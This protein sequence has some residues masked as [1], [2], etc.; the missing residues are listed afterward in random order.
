MAKKFVKTCALLCVPVLALCMAACKS[1]VGENSGYVLLDSAV[2]PTVSAPYEE[3]S[4]AVI[5][6]YLSVA[7]D[8]LDEDGDV[9][10]EDEDVQQAAIE[11]AAELYAYACYNEAYIDKYVYFSTQSGSTTYGSLGTS[12]ATSQNYRLIVNGDD[13][14]AGYKY[15]Y[16]IKKV[17][18]VSSQALELFK[19][20]FE[21][22]TL[23]FVVDTNIL[24]RLAGEDVHYDDEGYLTCTW[25]VESNESDWGVEDKPAI[26]KKS[27]DKLTLEGIKQDI[28]EVAS[29]DPGN[30]YIHG[31]IN[32]LKDGIVNYAKITPLDSELENTSYDSEDISAY[33]I[34]MQIDT[35]V[36]NSDEASQNMLNNSNGT[37]DCKW[38]EGGYTIIFWVWNNGLFQS[39]ILGESWTGTILGMSGSVSSATRVVYSYSDRD[40]DLTDKLAMLEE[41]KKQRG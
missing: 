28:E 9:D 36:A 5:S 38:D 3:E 6:E 21:D 12:E 13:N 35:S 18:S 1:D 27:G 14:T 40:T 25:V 10:Y 15:H 29:S 31:N 26:V 24:Y 23:R 8:Y 32:I 4:K 34:L 19:S 11:A 33:R 30:S 20:Q 41:A 17:D 16:T 37:S 7:E 39:Y 2:Y 22:A